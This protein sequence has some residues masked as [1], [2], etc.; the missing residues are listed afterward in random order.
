M[1][2]VLIIYATR[3]GQTEKV[4]NRI[5]MHLRNLSTEVQVVNA[6]NGAARDDIDLDTFDHLVIGGSLHAGGD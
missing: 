5:A 6:R 4:A 2:K 3:E 1:M